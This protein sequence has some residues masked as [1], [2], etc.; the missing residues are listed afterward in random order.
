LDIHPI[1]DEIRIFI[2]LVDSFSNERIS[3][4]LLLRVFIVDEGGVEEVDDFFFS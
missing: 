4:F 2:L 3:R 1:T